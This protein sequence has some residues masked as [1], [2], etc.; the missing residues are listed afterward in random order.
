MWKPIL[1][2]VPGFICWSLLWVGGNQ[3]FIRLS[4]D[5]FKM[6]VSGFPPTSSLI[7]LLV[8]SVLCSLASG[9]LAGWIARTSLIP[10]WVLAGILL[11]VGILVERGYW[12]QLPL[13]YHLSFLAALIPAVVAGALMVPRSREE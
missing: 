13:W 1:A 10:V 9:A 2:I 12:Q 6:P 3:V 11:V 7:I 5:A 4:P 8:F